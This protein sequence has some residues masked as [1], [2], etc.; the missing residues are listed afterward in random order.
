[1]LDALLIC[2]Q[3]GHQT[4]SLHCKIRC[5]N[6]GH[7]LDCSDLEIPGGAGVHHEETEEAEGE[8]QE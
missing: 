3:C 1:M 6:C 4:M 7:F 5:P 8:Q 2:E